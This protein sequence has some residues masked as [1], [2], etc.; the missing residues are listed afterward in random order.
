MQK[1]SIVC[2]CKTPF[3]PDNYT[4]TDIAWSSQENAE[5]FYFGEF[6]PRGHL[7]ERW[8]WCIDEKTRRRAI[9]PAW[10]SHG[11]LSHVHHLVGG[12]EHHFPIY[13]EF[14]HPNWRSLIFFRG[15]AKNHQPVM[16]TSCEHHG[17]SAMVMLPEGP[18]NWGSHIGSNCRGSDDSTPE[19]LSTQVFLWGKKR[20]R[21]PC[22]SHQTSLELDF[23]KEHIQLLQSIPVSTCFFTFFP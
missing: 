12:L 3:F 2:L 15:V 6:Q 5:K 20:Q 13:W 19:S 22:S 11:S 1:L 4:K 17:E 10:T 21:S 23:R 14:H 9:D 7:W 8:R 16:A 18:R